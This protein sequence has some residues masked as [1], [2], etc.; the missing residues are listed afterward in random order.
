M[1]LV[2]ACSR[3]TSWRAGDA[4]QEQQG[5]DERPQR[6]HHAA[7]LRRPGRRSCRRGR[8]HGARGPSPWRLPQRPLHG[9]AQ[10]LLPARAVLPSPPLAATLQPGVTAGS[11]TC[12]GQRPARPRRKAQPG[13][14]VQWEV[15]E[16]LERPAFR[17]ELAGRLSVACKVPLHRRLLGQHHRPCRMAEHEVSSTTT[18]QSS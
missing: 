13:A 12:L 4:V 1:L 5:L 2:R 10:D 15:P 16:P 6:R 18:W 8:H 9:A 17:L 7:Q 14:Q 3:L 11:C